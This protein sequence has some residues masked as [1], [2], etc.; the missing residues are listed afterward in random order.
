M[1][2]LNETLTR[3]MALAQQMASIYSR[4]PKVKAVLI[5]GA[6]ARGWGDSYSM[7]I[8]NIFWSEPPSGPERLAA[9]AEL[10]G[11][12]SNAAADGAGPCPEAYEL[13]GIKVELGHT[14]LET[15]EQYLVEVLEQYD[16]DGKKQ[17]LLADIQ[18]GL[19]LHGQALIES[20]Q[21]KIAHYPPELA[22]A[23]IHQNLCFN[24]AWSGRQALVERDDLLLLYNLYCQIEQQILTLLFGL[25]RIYLPHLQGKWLEQ[26]VAGMK[27]TPPALTLRL[28]QVFRL[29]PSSGV[30]LLQE[31]VEETLDLV[32]I[33]MPEI[34]VAAA[35]KKVK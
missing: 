32:E 17:I 16:P 7:L 1:N 11:A 23:V 18:H 10:G 3:R 19:P 15:L 28:K 20:W 25:N 34:N 2:K 5:A 9:L 8:L 13:Q 31:I 30:R 35:R 26:L 33:H 27:L 14:L 4:N 24:E 21:A 29:A 12:T 6:L 22:G